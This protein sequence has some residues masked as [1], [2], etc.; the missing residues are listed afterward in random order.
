MKTSEYKIP[1]P[2]VNLKQALTDVIDSIAIEG[3]AIG[4]I[5]TA[6][7]ELLSKAKKDAHDV[8]EF[9]DVNTLVSS[10]VRSI[11]TIQLFNHYELE[12]S[13]N[14]LQKIVDLSEYEDLEE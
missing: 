6:E 8:D 9:T 3:N 10:I 2:A 4:S 14:L 1:F 11:A 5:L 12:D 7:S 13:E